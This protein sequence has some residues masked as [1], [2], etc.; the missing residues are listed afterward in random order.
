MSSRVP[1]PTTTYGS[2]RDI[3]H[4]SGTQSRTG[5]ENLHDA[6]LRR[7]V[8]FSLSFFPIRCCAT[9]KSLGR[10]IS[11]WLLKLNM[12][13]IHHITPDI[14]ALSAKRCR[15]GDRRCH[16]RYPDKFNYV[17]YFIARP[18]ECAVDGR[19]LMSM[20]TVGMS[21]QILTR[22]LQ[23]G[24]SSQI[25]SYPRFAAR[26]HTNTLSVHGRFCSGV[27]RAKV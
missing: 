7:R 8:F 25:A 3:Q 19:W 9:A 10:A 11:T 18:S 16:R 5:I 23:D 21:G 2:R 24:V 20:D 1:D 4:S 14:Y 13:R 27:F 22:T 26:S 15:A 12:W 17:P 6:L